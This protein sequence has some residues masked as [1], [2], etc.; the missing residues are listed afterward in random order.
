MRLRLLLIAPAVLIAAAAAS[1]YYWRVARF[2]V[3]TDD[4]YVQADSTLVASRVPGYVSEVLVNDHQEVRVGQVLARIDDRD[5]RAAYDQSQATLQAARAQLANTNA[6]LARQPS[7]IAQAQAQLESAEAQLVFMRQNDA[8]YV[9]AAASGAATYQDRQQADTELRQRTAPR[10]QRRSS[11]SRFCTRSNKPPRPMSVPPKR[12]SGR[13]DS[14]YPTRASSPPSTAR[15]A[16]YPYRP[17][18][19]LRRAPG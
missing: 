13:R 7:I 2:H 8:R 4:A 18:T 1:I 12:A 11:R 16:N 14:T 15:S 17:V 9:S 3:A 5:F 19:M 6:E 10:S